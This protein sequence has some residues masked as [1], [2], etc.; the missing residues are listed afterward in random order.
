MTTRRT[1]KTPSLAVQATELAI[2]V[3]QVVAHR[4]TRMAL[5]GPL[6]S[7]RDRKEFHG[8]VAEKNRAFVE[9]W[10]AMAAQATIANQAL[11]ASYFQSFLA[12]AQGRQPSAIGAA[13][14]LQNAALGVLGKGL[15]PV[16]RKAT[17]NATRLART[18]LR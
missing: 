5:A 17:A 4:L 12:V 2:A 16:H 11:A 14:A 15:A 10:T 3:P 9:S 7:A 6:L 13:V 18:R 8:M 1:R